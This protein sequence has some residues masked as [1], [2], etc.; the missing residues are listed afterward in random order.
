MSTHEPKDTAKLASGNGNGDLNRRDFLLKL[1]L[2]LNVLAGAMIAIPLVGYVM[3]VFVK[4]PPL[5]W[6]ALGALE[7]FPEATTK[8]ATYENADDR[9]WGGEV[10]VIPC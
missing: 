3:S 4:R 1:G 7:K 6:T 8:L 9:E 5:K 10:A 2:G